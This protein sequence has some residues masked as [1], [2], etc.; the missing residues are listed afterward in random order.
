MAP[1]PWPHRAA[2]L[3]ACATFPLIW[4]GGLVTTYGAGMAVPDWPN[5]YG[6]ILF[7]FPW[8]GWN[9]W[10][11]WDVF[12]EHSHRLIGSAVG[13]CT[14][15]LLV[16]L[17]TKDSRLWMR[18]LGVVALVGVI[19]QGV[20]GGLRVT[21]GSLLLAK[22]HACTAQAFFGFA[23]A[24]IAFSSI[25]WQILG[26]P[27]RHPAGAALRRW[28]WTAV[29]AIYLQ[30]VLGALIRHLPPLADPIWFSLWFWP[31]FLLALGLAVGIPAL[32][33]YVLRR[34][35]DQPRLR[36]LAWLLIGLFSLQ[37]LLGLSVWVVRFGFPRWFTDYLWAVEYTIVQGGG[38]QVTIRTAHLAVASLTFA[39][40][41]SLAL[42]TSR[43]VVAETLRDS[44][45]SSRVTP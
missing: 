40:A 35:G 5:T 36:R 9:P 30:L 12:L 26:E 21:E 1:S 27:R 4:M 2:W 18:R 29:V 8:K 44:I 42:W 23:A 38:L 11:F 13:I 37:F 33:V 41:V 25:D 28:T 45:A 20:L 15:T 6:Y 17:W 31:H 16:L 39:T 7:L 34:A 32:A 22:F 24:L 10:Q 43:S 19:V 3:L 14:I